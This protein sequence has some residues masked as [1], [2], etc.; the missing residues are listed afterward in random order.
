[1]Q[2]NKCF[3]IHSL[4]LVG[5]RIFKKLKVEFTDKGD[6]ELREQP[7]ISLVIGSNGT[8]KSNLL[9]AITDIFRELHSLRETG[10]R[11]NTITG[12][13][14]LKYQFKSEIYTFGN[15]KP[16]GLNLKS[17]TN[18]NPYP[19]PF[20]HDSNGNIDFA[21][22]KL[23]SVILAS[24]LMVTD[25]FFND[26][27]NT[28]PFYKYLGVRTSANQA[29]TKTYIRRTVEMLL[30]SFDTE[31]ENLTR[32]MLGDLLVK[33]DF[34]QELHIRYQPVYKSHFFNRSELLTIERFRGFFE[35]Y[36]KYSKR[37]TPPWGFKRYE[38]IKG[39]KKL[40]K[41][42]VDGCNKLVKNGHLNKIGKSRTEYFSFEVI[43]DNSICDFTNL[44]TELSLLDLVRA[45]ELIFVKDS[46]RFSFRDS[47]SGEQHVVTT[48]IAIMSQIKQNALVLLDEPEISLHPNWQMRYVSE[49]LVETFHN[50][51]SS[52][53]IISTHSHFLVSDVRPECSK[54]IGLETDESG[55]KVTYPVPENTLGWSAEQLLLEVFKTPTTRNYFLAEKIGEILDLIAHSSL[56][57]HTDEIKERVKELVD[58][59]V[60]HLSKEDPLKDVLDKLIKEYG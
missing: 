45:P 19:K 50:Y 4:E 41:S 18:K 1:M 27:K 14:N 42:I 58:L 38:K 44:F 37:S 35:D 16:E 15:Y 12:F 23:P 30:D 24:S 46:T 34:N 28:L 21:N 25:K 29:G 60:E 36:T 3:R 5:H 10:K 40:V 7:Y 54:V 59:Q 31:N 49:F 2:L 8:G 9:R 57:D 52:H 11:S 26:V 17:L 39:D 33:L 47:S 55:L 13:F 20:L 43:E 53:F 56:E 6:Q 48:L 22:A 51:F 32:F